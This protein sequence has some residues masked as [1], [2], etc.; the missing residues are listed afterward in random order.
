MF[1]AV[2]VVLLIFDSNMHSMKNDFFVETDNNIGNIF[3]VSFKKF[4]K[5]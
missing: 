3:T 5:Y 2:D 1:Y 4:L